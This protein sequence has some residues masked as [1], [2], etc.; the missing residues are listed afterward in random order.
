MSFQGS[1]QPALVCVPV[2]PTGNNNC[3]HP[4][5]W[6]VGSSSIWGPRCD[7]SVWPILPCVFHCSYMFQAGDI[8]HVLSWL[9]YPTAVGLHS[10]I[11]FIVDGVC[12]YVPWSPMCAALSAV[13]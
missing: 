7:L 11:S 9:H 3:V 5:V 8:L 13:H 6:R 12:V 10:S 1:P 2:L 4:G